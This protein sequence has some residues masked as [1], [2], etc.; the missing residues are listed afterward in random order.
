MSGLGKGLVTCS[1]GK[2][3]EVRGLKVT[4]IKCDPYL[5]VDA[6][7][8]NPYIHGE[9]FV[10]DDGYE[11]DMDLG[12]YERFL[13]GDFNQLNNVTSGQV[14]QEVIRREREGGYLGRCVQIIPHVT[15]EIKRRIRLVASRSKADI[16]LV[17]SG[18]T[19]GDIEG[20]PFMEAFRQMRNE[21]KR[22]DTLLTHVTLVPVLEAVGEPKT[23]PTQHSVKEL[24]AIGLQPD[25][26][27]A[28]I[29]SG[30][31]D[32]P[33]RRKIAL[34][35]SVEERAVFSSVNVSTLYELPLVLE[36]QGMGDVVCEYLELDKAEPDWS[37]WSNM[38]STFTDPTDPV[39][40]AMC[41]KYAEL[42]D[43]Y[44]SVNEALRHSA[45][46]AG[47]KVRIEWIETEE[48]EED[49]S[50]LCIL[51]DYDGVLVPGGFGK[52]GAE[53]KIRAINYC[54]LNDKPFLGICYGFQ[55]ATVEYARNVVGL[56]Y[57]HSTECDPD[58]PHPVIDLLPE[59]HE[60]KEL[61][62][63]MRLGSH[64]IDVMDGTLIHRLYGSEIIHERH[65]HRWEVNPNYWEDLKEAGAIF[66]GW[67][68]N[69]IRKE[70]LEI[71]DHYFFL[72]TQF[73]PEFKSRPWAPSPPYYGFVKAAYD[74]KVGKPQ[75]EF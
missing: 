9:V 4:A 57:A 42:A 30:Q 24:R 54:R 27:T 17:E 35:C 64:K 50:N 39:K 62:G 56:E 65:R 43:C 18:G 71:K 10:L 16:V 33:Q 15:D 21:E 34:Y 63:S 11:A 53:G 60:V 47:C 7:T 38:V 28:R 26:I 51:E 8:M 36:S 32:V 19:V 74:K 75:P 22:G 1:I 59:Q 72:C 31:L 69:G 13:D 37:E 67:S 14:Y 3:L 12:T 45:A 44:V 23:K 70:V 55:L 20:L 29:E 41:G 68:D 52:R 25:V 2:M 58:T 46:K 66:T 61:G 6:G 40:I 48:F 5:N 73:H 49:P